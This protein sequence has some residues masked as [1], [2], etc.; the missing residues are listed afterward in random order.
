[1]SKLTVKKIGSEGGIKT[2]DLLK[3]RKKETPKRRW[4]RGILLSHWRPRCYSPPSPSRTITMTLLEFDINRKLDLPQS[5]LFNA[6]ESKF[7]ISFE[8]CAYNL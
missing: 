8:I 2:E 7:L 4:C 3:E 1:M 6:K 5:I